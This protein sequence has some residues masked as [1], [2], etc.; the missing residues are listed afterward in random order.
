V[1]YG[2]VGKSPEGSWQPGRETRTLARLL[3]GGLLAVWWRSDLQFPATR[4]DRRWLLHYPTCRLC[5][6]LVGTA[7]F[8]FR[9]VVLHTGMYEP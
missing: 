8:R 5:V 1:T 6:Y 9:S 2:L 7:G 3:S 4:G